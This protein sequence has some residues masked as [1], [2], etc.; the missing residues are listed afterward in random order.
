MNTIK[1]YSLVYGEGG[2]DMAK[3]TSIILG[4]HFESFISRQVKAG[5]YGSASEVVR[6]SLRLLEEHEQ[7]V[8]VLRSA[9]VEGEESGIAGPLD[10]SKIKQNARKEV[11]L[12]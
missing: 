4:D 9:L 10:M 5:R 7:K 2:A 3:N 12:A 11:G 1:W 8:E 6:A